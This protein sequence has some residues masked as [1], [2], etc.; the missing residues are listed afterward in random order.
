MG[1]PPTSHERCKRLH[2]WQMNSRIVSPWV[3]SYGFLHR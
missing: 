2:H 1:T 3:T